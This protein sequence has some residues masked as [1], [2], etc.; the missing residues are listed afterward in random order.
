[1]P[2]LRAPSRPVASPAGR[3]IETDH[4]VTDPVGEGRSPTARRSGSIP[5][6]PLRRPPDDSGTRGDPELGLGGRG[7]PGG[8]VLDSPLCF[9]IVGVAGVGFGLLDNSGL[10]GAGAASTALSGAFLALVLSARR[11]EQSPGDG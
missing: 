10:I 7:V 11:S 9:L 5:D 4:Q 8:D 1:M 2:P 3:A 6:G